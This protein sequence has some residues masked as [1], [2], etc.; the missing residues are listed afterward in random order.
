MIARETNCFMSQGRAIRWTLTLFGSIEDLIVE[1][2]K[3]CDI[4][5][6]EVTIE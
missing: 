3:R 5:N 4:G 6:D 1:N 2:D